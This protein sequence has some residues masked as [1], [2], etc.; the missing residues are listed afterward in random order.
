MCDANQIDCID[1][2]HHFYL[3]D[4]GFCE[5]REEMEDRGDSMS[6]TVGVIYIL[7]TII[8][9]H[10]WLFKSRMNANRFINADKLEE[11]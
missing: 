10:A 1:C 3:N 2:D 8:V 6:A 5:D 7:F 11:E 4:Y 9:T